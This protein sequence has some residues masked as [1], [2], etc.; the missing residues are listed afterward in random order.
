LTRNPF[1]GNIRTFQDEARNSESGNEPFPSDGS[2]MADN[3]S[4]T[5]K[6]ISRRLIFLQWA[7]LRFSG[8][9]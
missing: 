7:V 8:A 6:K 9:A 2:H 4:I 5:D 3:G 1:T